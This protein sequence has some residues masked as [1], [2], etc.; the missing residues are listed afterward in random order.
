MQFTS[1]SKK[2]WLFRVNT[3]TDRVKRII[4]EQGISKISANDQVAYKAMLVLVLHSGDR[5]LIEEY[6]DL[7]ANSESK[8]VVISDRAFIIDKLQGLKNKRQI[9]GTQLKMINGNLTPLPIE[10]ELDVDRK[11]G[12]LGL[13]P[14]SKYISKFKKDNS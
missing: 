2:E 6:L 12:E 11:R 5:T 10:D 3:R 13:A 9:Y 4:K 7:H 8:D 1:I 14:L